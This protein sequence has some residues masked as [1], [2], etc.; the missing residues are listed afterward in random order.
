M[1][2]NIW[3]TK[4]IGCDIC[5]FVHLRMTCGHYIKLEYGFDMC[6]YFF[7]HIYFLYIYIA[8]LNG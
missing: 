7:N 6:K 2:T 3:C 8:W 1:Y 5:V 4:Q